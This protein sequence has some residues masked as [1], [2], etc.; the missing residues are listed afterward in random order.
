MSVPP[1][2]K[3][4]VTTPSVPARRTVAVSRPDDVRSSVS[5]TSVATGA[6]GRRGPKGDRGP[7]GMVVG[8]TPP[9]DHDVVWMDTSGNP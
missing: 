1:K 5:T 8:D 4:R 3:V 6:I 7:A 2:I 9:D